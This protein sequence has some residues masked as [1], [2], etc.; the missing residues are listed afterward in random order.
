MLTAYPQGSGEY[1][2]DTNTTFTYAIYFRCAVKA[3]TEVLTSVQEL[4]AHHWLVWDKAPSATLGGITDV[5]A[6][7]TP[8]L[9]HI[10]HDMKKRFSVKRY[11]KQRVT[12]TGGSTAT[13][14]GPPC[15]G[16]DGFKKMI[17]CKFVTSWKNNPTGSIGDVESGALIW[18]TC[19]SSGTPNQTA[20]LTR[21]SYYWDHTMY[22]D[23]I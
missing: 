20:E 10:K 7:D 14:R 22:F 11:F 4:Y 17:K 13:T 1:N 9:Y 19:V 8:W 2:R 21:L 15:H 18:L 16:V 3:H 5:F 23:C 6:G 12:T